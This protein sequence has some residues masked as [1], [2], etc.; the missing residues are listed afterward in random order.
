MNV[1]AL[2]PGAARTAALPVILR[3]S[4]N[5]KE[6]FHSQ[7]PFTPLGL[8]ASVLRGVRELG[9]VRPTAI[10]DQAIP[11]AIEGRDILA[12]SITGSG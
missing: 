9:F 1:C 11:A 10:Q 8:H 4:R 6:R 12:S 5:R 7:M 3:F 2:H